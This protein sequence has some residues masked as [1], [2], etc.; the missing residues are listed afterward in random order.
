VQVKNLRG[1]RMECARHSTSTSPD[2]LK[3]HS[4]NNIKKDMKSKLFFG[5][6]KGKIKF[7]CEGIYDKAFF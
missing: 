3:K 5:K 2:Y 7:S 1:T 6:I 4:Q